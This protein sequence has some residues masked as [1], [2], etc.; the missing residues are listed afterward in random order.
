MMRTRGTELGTQQPPGAPSQMG[1][2][3]RGT[4][5]IV[6]STETN[7]IRNV[8]SIGQGAARRKPSPS[9]MSTLHIMILDFT[10]ARLYNALPVDQIF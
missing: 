6:S 9:Y 7:I 5:A 4:F 8:F 2:F 1:A 3:I 10:M